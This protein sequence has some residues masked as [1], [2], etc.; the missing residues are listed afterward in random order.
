M[1]RPIGIIAILCVFS[2]QAETVNL[3]GTVK[4]SG[5]SA[6]IAGVKVSLAK[7]KTLSVLTAADGSF[8]I[9][10]GTPVL[11]P[12]Q[13]NAALQFTLTGNMLVLPYGYTI[14]S[15]GIDLFSSAG[16][17]VAS[18]PFG[19]TRTGRQGAI[20]PRLSPGLN[21][22]RLNIN[23][24]SY[25]QALLSVGKDIF[26]KNE[27]P[28][29]N[30]SL[31]TLAKQSAA[32]AVDTL[33]AEKNGY[34]TAR[35]PLDNYTKQNI[36]VT[37]DSSAQESGPCT[38]QVLQ[39]AVDSYIKAQ[40]AGDP[41]KMLLAPQVRYLENL[42]VTTEDK[43]ICK[44]ALTID[45]HRDFLDVDS[46]RTFSEVI[47]TKGGHPYVIGTR[48][49][50]KAGKITEVDAIVTD[51]GDWLFNA[52][53]YY[54]KS[55]TEKWDTLPIAE[56]STRQELINCANAY[57]AI[58]EVPHTDTIPFGSPCNRLEG[59]SYTQ[60][61]NVGFPTG[62]TNHKLTNRD[63]VVDVAMGTINMFC[64]LDVGI[65][66][67]SPDSHLIRMVNKKIRYVHTLTI[68]GEKG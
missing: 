23:G 22:V 9:S 63:F 35:M 24:A 27:T 6:G 49:R 37:L 32:A 64:Y 38:R 16:K 56:R 55:T 65:K 46:C 61:C 10:G 58:F 52:K 11:S 42:A 19:F 25:S 57:G 4:K 43:S 53:T 40:E 59:G 31:F 17:K 51:T 30:P 2:A 66:P 45:F 28:D 20:L 39:A 8:F 34:L 14:I 13:K 50:V 41:S 48:L 62:K 68:W 12:E 5:G 7:V 15:G 36:A 47:V 29:N 1:I 18:A 3:S 21:I 60:T 26:L 54:E 44:K 33:V 67:T